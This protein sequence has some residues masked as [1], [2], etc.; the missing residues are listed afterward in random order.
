MHTDDDTEGV[1]LPITHDYYTNTKPNNVM[2]IMTD[3][4]EDF[5][6]KIEDL[7]IT[8]MYQ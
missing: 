3:D 1:M 6:K 5:I 8:L 7:C 2:Y 4:V